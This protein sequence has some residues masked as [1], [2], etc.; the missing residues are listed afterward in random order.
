MSE[1]RDNLIRGGMHGAGKARGVSGCGIFCASAPCI[2]PH[3]GMVSSKNTANSAL[4]GAPN[5]KAV[6]VVCMR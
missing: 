5:M 4:T 1:T 2:L 6:I 3:G